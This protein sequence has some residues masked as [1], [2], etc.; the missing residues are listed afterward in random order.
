MAV[1]EK[2]VTKAQFEEWA[3]SLERRLYQLRLLSAQT[4]TETTPTFVSLPD[5]P[6]DY[7]GAGRRLVVVNA[8]E[9]GLSF[10]GHIRLD[11]ESA[12]VSNPPTASELNTLF[13][14]VPDGFTALVQD[15]DGSLWLIVRSSSAWWYVEFK[16]AS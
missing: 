4:Q 8:S 7:T 6:S 12:N 1:G 13:G 15:S 14:S 5:T 3:R 11:I 16:Q 9:D 10:G 2:F